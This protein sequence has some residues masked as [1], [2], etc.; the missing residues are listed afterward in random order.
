MK[1]SLQCTH[2][3]VQLGYRGLVAWVTDVPHFDTAL[4]ASVDMTRWVTDGDSTHHLPVAK[5]I[6]LSCVA[7]DAWTDQCIRRKRHR[8]HLSVSAHMKGVG[9][10]R[11]KSVKWRDKR[12]QKKR[13]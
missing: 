2:K 3:A 6:D 11:E 13:C 4:A 8:L 1:A 9:T 10:G 7:R 5:S 12:W